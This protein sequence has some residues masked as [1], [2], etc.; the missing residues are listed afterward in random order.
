MGVF[1]KRYIQ[2]RR[3]DEGFGILD[4]IVEALKALEDLEALGALKLSTS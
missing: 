3:F 1:K 2:V 4:G